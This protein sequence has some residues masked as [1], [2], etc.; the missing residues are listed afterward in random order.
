MRKWGPWAPT[1]D[2]NAASMT[3]Y[4]A[5]EEATHTDDAQDVEDGWPHNGPHSH[6]SFGNEN[7]W[8]RSHTHTHMQRQAF[9]E[10][11]AKVY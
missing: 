10:S 5:R 1:G 7:T 4:L 8:G 6:V 9:T 2:K 3:S 11:S